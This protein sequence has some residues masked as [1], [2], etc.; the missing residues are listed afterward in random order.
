[1]C[2]LWDWLKNECI[3][4]LTIMEFVILTHV[5]FLAFVDFGGGGE[6]LW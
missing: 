6:E 1:V 2:H 4:G 3:Q 5:K